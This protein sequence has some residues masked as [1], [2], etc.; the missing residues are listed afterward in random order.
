MAE[1]D[2]VIS[3]APRYMLDPVNGGGHTAA[4]EADG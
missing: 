1:A 3:E 4:R 2:L